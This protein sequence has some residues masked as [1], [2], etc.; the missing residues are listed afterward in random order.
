MNDKRSVEVGR[1]A[2]IP[3]SPLTKWLVVGFCVDVIALLFSPASKLQGALNNE[4]ASW[5]P[6][7]AQSTQVLEEI[8]AFQSTNEYPAVVVY[9]RPSGI[10]PQDLSAVTGQVARFNAVEPV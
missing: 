6:E 1:L 9:E 8:S 4:A 2:Q 10:T 7:D 3:S 5:L